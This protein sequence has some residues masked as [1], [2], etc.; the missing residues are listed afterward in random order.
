MKAGVCAISNTSASRAANSFLSPSLSPITCHAVRYLCARRW[1]YRDVLFACKN[2]F[3]SSASGDAKWNKPLILNRWN[4]GLFSRFVPQIKMH[5]MNLIWPLSTGIFFFCF[6]SFLK[7]TVH[8]ES[9]LWHF[10]IHVTVELSFT[11][12]KNA[13]QVIAS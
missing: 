7:G 13:E 3:S 12:V 2:K 6:R 10:L 11:E 4:G 8:S 1:I 5:L 9:K